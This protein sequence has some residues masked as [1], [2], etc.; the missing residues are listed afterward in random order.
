MDVLFGS[1][2]VRELLSTSDFDESSSLSVPDLRLLIDRL[3]IRSLHIKEKV[4]D[5]VISHHKDFSEIFSHCSNL[6]SKT[7]DISTDVSNV[8]SLISNHPID[9]EIRETTAEISS[10]TRELKEKKELL[11]V[12]QT[13]VNL[14]ERLKLVKED[15]KNGRLIEAAESMRV[16]KKALLIRDEDDDD[17]DDSGMSE[18][19]EPLVFGLLRK[20]WKDCFDEF[21]ELLVR[22]MDEAVKFEHG[23]GGKV[24]VKFKLSV[25]GLK[26][27]V[28]LRTVL[29]A[30][31]VIGVLDYGLAKVADLIVKFVVIPTVSNGSRF[32]FVEEL[33]QETMEK[34]EA[35]L[36]LV[37]SSGSQV[38][39]P[40]IYSNIIQVIKFAYIFLCLKNDRWMRCFGRLSW[41]RI[42]EL[43]IVHFLSKAVPDDASK[44]SEFQKIIE[45]TSEFENKLEDMKIISASDDKD[46]RLS[47][48]AQNIE[49]HF[50]SRKKIEILAKARNLLLQCDF[51]LPPDFSEQAV[52]LLFLPER[53]II[54]KAGAHLMELVHQTLRDVCLSSARVSMEFYHAAR[55]T[56]LLY[57]AIIPVKL[58]KQLNSINQVAI[59]VHNDCLFLAQEIL[60]LA[61]EYRPD[62]P[63]CLKDQA[64]FL[65]MAPRFH[66]MA[67]EVLHRQIQLVS[68]NL[69]EAIDGADG[70]QNTHQMQQ[71]ESAKL[72]IDQVIFILEKIR[73]IWEPLLPPS[74]Y[75]KS[76]CTVLDSLFSRLVEDILLLDD[77]AAEET[78]QLQRLIQIL[79][80][81][82]SFLF[83]SLNSIHER[84]KLQEDVTH[85]P[86]DEL[87]SSLS[88]L[89]K[90][91][92]LLDMPLKSITNASESGELVRCGYTSS[93]VQNFVKA[94]YTD[95][96]LRKECLWRIQSANW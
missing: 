67:E 32:D 82:L 61:F 49:V 62:F 87:I 66:Q 53:C 92:D 1:I 31:E 85:I 16:L 54:S 80:E 3:Q 78:L 83:D 52:Q 88:K 34:D 42:S 11:V 57:E 55:D 8:L 40:S 22:V 47:E 94:V 5:Y 33:D 45:L 76:M 73:I 38:D 89:R 13:I 93:E 29:T 48:Y 43:I 64:I 23:N 46:R 10:K 4:R 35:I 37:S 30:M 58:E 7:E 24:R 44:L 18:K 39:I 68:F 17:D 96:P 50:A 72:S 15:L 74:T 71:Y 28:E 20:E 69:K 14:V 19:S 63:S 84:E 9:I 2:D 86:L 75:K 56:L 91:A 25:S 95:S 90:L 65:D 36:G 81:N 77:M 51:S 41:P 27:E 79:L 26:E 70:F 60:G 6:S 59:L 21:Q 12:V